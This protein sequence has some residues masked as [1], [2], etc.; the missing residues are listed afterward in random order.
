MKK[1]IKAVVEVLRTRFLSRG[2]KVVEF[3]K[4]IR[5]YVGTRYAVA[6]NSGTSALHLIIICSP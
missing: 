3:E 5:E 1:D 4:R 2:P 6:V